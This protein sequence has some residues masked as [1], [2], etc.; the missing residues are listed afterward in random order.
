MAALLSVTLHRIYPVTFLLIF[1]PLEEIR[2]PL[3]MSVLDY[4]LVT[5]KSVL[6][7][8]NLFDSCLF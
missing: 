2:S 4:I 1:L 6:T 7:A 8:V 5:I 3:L